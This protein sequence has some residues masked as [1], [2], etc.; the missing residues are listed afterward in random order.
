MF[1]VAEHITPLHGVHHV[2]AAIWAVVGQLQG[3]LSARTPG[4]DAAMSHRNNPVVTLYI[5][6]EE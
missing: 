5:A 3:T 2:F 6:L 1:L 4:N